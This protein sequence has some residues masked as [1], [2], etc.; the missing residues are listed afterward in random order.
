MSEQELLQ[1]HRQISE[2]AQKQD[3]CNSILG[4]M[5]SSAESFSNRFG[6]NKNP[7][8][9]ESY[10][11]YH[12]GDL[13]NEY[14]LKSQLII[15]IKI[16]RNLVNHEKMKGRKYTFPDNL[17]PQDVKKLVIIWKNN[18]KKED[19]IYYNN[20]ISILDENFDINFP[21]NQN[22]VSC[23]KS[24]QGIDPNQFLNIV[25]NIMGCI[26]RRAAQVGLEA[27]KTG[28]INNKIMMGST[29]S[30]IPQLNELQFSSINKG[31]DKS[32]EEKRKII[33]SLDKTFW[34]YECYYYLFCKK[35]K[36]SVR[37]NL[38]YGKKND[39]SK[40]SIEELESMAAKYINEFKNLLG[41][42]GHYCENDLKEC[43]NSACDWYSNTKAKLFLD[44]KLIIEDYYQNNC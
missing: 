20:I 40:H 16:F 35:N 15:H 37:L 18:V 7:K 24:P 3:N 11:L 33:D 12:S 30:F 41:K 4:L 19:Q 1:I 29:E 21:S 22:K 36:I 43:Y 10:N 38:N 5:L 6:I 28:V 32:E 26:D 31:L 2:L 25:P 8:L 9:F 17:G 39:Y 14:D 42:Y 44:L 27:Q 34:F 13:K 23:N